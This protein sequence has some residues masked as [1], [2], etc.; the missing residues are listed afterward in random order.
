MN[1]KEI[2]K[3]KDDI[4]VL[5]NAVRDMLNL[6]HKLEKQILILSAKK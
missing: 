1:E 3:M 6:I 2:Q 4:Q 5:A